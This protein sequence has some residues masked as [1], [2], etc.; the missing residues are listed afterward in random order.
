MVQWGRLCALKAGGPGSIP[1]LGTG[2]YVPQQRPGAAR[3]INKLTKKTHSGVD[4]DSEQGETKALGALDTHLHKPS[5]GNRKPPAGKQKAPSS[6]RS[7]PP[8]CPSQPEIEGERRNGRPCAVR[9]HSD[10]TRLT[11]SPLLDRQTHG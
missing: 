2:S 3:W 7:P 9:G 4:V 11:P 10:P 6:L 1:R 8:A 5:Q